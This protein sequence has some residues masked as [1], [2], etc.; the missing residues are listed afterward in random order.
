MSLS[1]RLGLLFAS[2]MVLTFIIFTVAHRK[3]N[4]KYSIVWMLWAL[5]ALL[6]AIFPESFYALS[7]LLGIQMP[8]N[9]VFLIMTALLYALTFY[10]YIMITKHNEEIIKLTYEISALKKQLDEQKKNER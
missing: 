4:I 5:F 2:L 9:T 1:L 7:D 10:V 6:M 8:V 3:L